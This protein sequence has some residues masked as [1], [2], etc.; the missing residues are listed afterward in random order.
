MR[1]EE[2]DSSDSA[3]SATARSASGRHKTSSEP[4]DDGTA[5]SGRSLWF[6]G[7]ATAGGRPTLIRCGDVPA[8]V[9]RSTVS[10]TMSATASAEIGRSGWPPQ[11]LDPQSALDGPTLA[12]T[13]RAAFGPT[14][15]RMPNPLTLLSGC[16]VTVEP[17]LV[18]PGLTMCRS[19]LMLSDLEGCPGDTTSD[20]CRL[21]M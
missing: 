6:P 16:A 18:S 4:G 3:P 12:V 8:A 21:F 11:T 17:S 10:A 5:P 7:A 9:T 15:V 20:D 2:E 14:S 1:T 13:Y 19:M